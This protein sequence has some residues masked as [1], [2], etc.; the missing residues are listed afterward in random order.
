MQCLYVGISI[1]SYVKST[2]S[3]RKRE[4][5]AESSYVRPERLTRL[6]DRYLQYKKGLD[7]L[8]KRI[9][10]G[11]MTKKQ[12]KEA[13]ATK[14]KLEAE[15]NNI[16]TEK[17]RVLNVIIFPA[18]ANLTVLLEQM[19][20]YPY[21]QDIFEDDVKELFMQASSK[22]PGRRIFHRFVEACVCKWERG[23]QPEGSAALGP[24]F[25]TILGEYMQRAVF[26]MMKEMMSVKFEDM[27]FREQIIVDDMTRPI[28]WS[29]YF[30]AEANR[31]L[32]SNLKMDKDGMTR[33]E[34]SRPA[35]F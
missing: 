27:Y 26:E 10:A 29:K 3:T 20:E 30:A 25:R 35:L 19:R 21:I 17:V 14:T 28:V 9:N 8:S 15:K 1:I 13:E 31:K 24:D 18:M 6:I 7:E 23:K 4:Q 34:H 2:D 32:D 33:G 5:K 22:K 11:G 16:D 12:S